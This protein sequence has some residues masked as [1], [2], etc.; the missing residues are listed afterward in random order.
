V[1][2]S[3]VLAVHEEETGDLG[4]TAVAEALKVNRMLKDL[5]FDCT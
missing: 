2:T 3:C 5:N 4:A 1:L